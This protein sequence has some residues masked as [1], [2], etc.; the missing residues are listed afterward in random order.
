L[1]KST[2]GGQAAIQ[3][4]MQYAGFLFVCYLFCGAV[5]KGSDPFSVVKYKEIR[6]FLDVRLFEK[7]SR[8]LDGR[9]V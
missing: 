2:E 1:D 5:L 6:C 3:T 7:I 9:G 4:G 8:L